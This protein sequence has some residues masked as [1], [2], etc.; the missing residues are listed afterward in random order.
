[1]RYTTIPSLTGKQLIRL[2][3]KDGWQPRRR[4]KHGIALAKVVGDTT[5]VT[6]VPDTNDDLRD[7]LD[8][9]LSVKQT[10]LGKS[11]LLALLNT[12]GL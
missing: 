2:L 3:Q 11:G 1:M 9:I 12:Y 5:R 7:V 8:W 4:A 10:G 6:V